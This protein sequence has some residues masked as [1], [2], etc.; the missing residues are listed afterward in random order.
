MRL[1][2]GFSGFTEHVPHQA[3]AAHQTFAAL[4][5]NSITARPHCT[6]SPPIN[7]AAHRADVAEI[8]T[9]SSTL[10]FSS[11]LITVG[12]LDCAEFNWYT[13]SENPVKFFIVTIQK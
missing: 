1:Q 13:I 10:R 4:H 12:G 11:V 3:H 2:R 6:R 8:A 5:F 9:A 7:A